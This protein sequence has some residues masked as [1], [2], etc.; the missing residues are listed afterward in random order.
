M[1]AAGRGEGRRHV[2]D[3]LQL[4]RLD[5]NYRLDEMSAALGAVPVEWLDET[6]AD[7]AVVAALYTELL[8]RLEDVAAP[9][10]AP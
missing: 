3:A 2:H 5:F 10:V 7:R 1:I 9:T 8:R 6:L 4:R